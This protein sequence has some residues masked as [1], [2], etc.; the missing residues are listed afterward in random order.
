MGKKIAIICFT[1]VWMVLSALSCCFAAQ[2]SVHEIKNVY[3][4]N[5]KDGYLYGIELI[6][7]K[8]YIFSV[9]IETGEQ[10]Y[11]TYPIKDDHGV[12]FLMDLV[13]GNNGEM[14]VYYSLL[15]ESDSDET[16]DIISYC[17][18]DNGRIIPKWDMKEISDKSFLQFRCQQDGQLVLETIDNTTATMYRFYLNED[19]TAA[20][21]DSMQLPAEVSSV[22]S[23]D[24]GVWALSNTGDVYKVEDNNITREIFINDGSKIGIQ[25]TYYD[26]QEDGMHFFNLDTGLNYKITSETDYQEIELCPDHQSAE[27][28]SFDVS[29]VYNTSEQDGIYVGILATEDGRSIPV[30]YGEK[31]YALE[32]LTW[33]AGKVFLTAFLMI[34]GV[35]AVLLIYFYVFSRLFKRK[36]GAPVLGIA[37]MLM[38]PIITFSMIQLYHVMEQKLPDEKAQKIQQ[39]TVLNDILKQK[40][41]MQQL[42]AIRDADEN[43]FEE[44]IF[45][46]YNLIQPLFI[47][48]MSTN[49]KELVNSG[50]ASFLYYCENGEIYPVSPIYQLNLPVKYQMSASNYLALKEA[51]ETGKTVCT[52]YNSYLGRFLTILSPIKNENGEVIAVLE[53]SENTLILETNILSNRQNIEKLFFVIGTLIFLMIVLVFWINTRSLKTLRQAMTQMAEGNLKARANIQGNHE[54]AV[55]AKRFDHMAELI[56]NRVTEVEAYQNKY[57]AFVPS[58]LF[59]L[60]RKNGIRGALS[61]DGKDFTA[62]VLTIHTLHEKNGDSNPYQESF[63]DYHEY[64]NKQ[65]SV[66]HTYGGIIHKIFRHGEIAIFT[67]DTQHN[68]IECAIA[69]LE[70]LKDEDEAFYVGIADEQLRFGVIGLPKRMVT[71]MISEHGSLSVF[72]QHMAAKFGTPILITGRAAGRIPNFARYYRTR[73]IGYLQMTSSDKLE[74][75]YEVLNG[76]TQE[77]QRLKLDT[78]AEFEDGVRLFMAKSYAYARRRFIHVLQQ[79]PKDGVAKEYITLCDQHLRDESEETWL[80]KF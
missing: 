2:K 42:E 53:T 57:E 36:D 35:T 76:D 6:E 37:I 48:N 28:K 63:S 41:D 30:I 14:Y 3:T 47:Q 73:I 54:I 74:A 13:M 70:K 7:N 75:V 71:A 78:K 18:F 45:V 5:Y 17:D 65:I 44:V 21:K 33:P 43:T 77:R 32:Q 50:V 26:L 52:E 27:A 46:Y 10:Q 11:F 60:L 49:S 25:N 15:A 80:D 4:A 16:A 67:K 29:N 72:L 68:A 66:I 9:N 24:T 62:T 56:E 38:I 58:K 20:L 59:Y 22:V 40:I 23:Q 34:I 31:E 1:C 19:G 55:I 39:L 79:D 64:L 61:G 8:Y 69:V 51:A 12:V